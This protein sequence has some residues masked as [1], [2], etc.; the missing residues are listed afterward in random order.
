MGQRLMKFWHR[1]METKL[2]HKSFFGWK[3]FRTAFI[4]VALMGLTFLCSQLIQFDLIRV[5]SN[6]HQALERF[7]QLYIPP[8]FKEMGK[9][10]EAIFVTVLLAITAGTVG[11]ILAYL[12]ALSMSKQTGKNFI[13]KFLVRGLATFIRNVPSSIWAIILLM[14]FWFGEFLALLVMTMGTFGF[15]A[16]LFSDMIDETNPHSIEAL[17]ATGASYWQ[18]IFQS[19]LPETLPTAISWALYSVEL[20]IRESTLIGMLAG[21]G[22]GHLIGIFKHYRRFDQLSGAVILV[23]I[24]IISFDQ[25]SMYIRKRI[26]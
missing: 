8:N 22:I 19:V 24:L 1:E 18:I 10:A 4:V 20:N 12:A 6:A 13:M 23:V 9:L 25:L 11:S 17:E 3:R 14:A 16:R 21:G 2:E 5:F 7:T 15:T 26:L